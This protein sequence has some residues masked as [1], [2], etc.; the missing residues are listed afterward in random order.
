MSEPA[1][2][3]Q[4]PLPPEGAPVTDVWLKPLSAEAF[5]ELLARGLESMQGSEG[6]DMAALHAWFVRKYPTATDRL[7]YIR[8]KMRELEAK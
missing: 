1:G 6:E 2:C 8:R 4:M 7:R 3:F 5:A